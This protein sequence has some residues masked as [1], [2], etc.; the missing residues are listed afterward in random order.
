[1]HTKS[2]RA[3]FGEVVCATLHSSGIF[4]SAK[5]PRPMSEPGLRDYGIA[6]IELLPWESIN[7][8]PQTQDDFTTKGRTQLFDRF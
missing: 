5:V 2:S 8:I 7:I 1:M 4:S 6:G 3:V